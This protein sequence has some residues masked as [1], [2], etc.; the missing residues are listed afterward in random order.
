MSNKKQ[1]T[2]LCLASYEKGFNFLTE[3]KNQGNRVLLVTSEKLKDA[4]WPEE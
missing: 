2:V 4:G 3:C 1:L